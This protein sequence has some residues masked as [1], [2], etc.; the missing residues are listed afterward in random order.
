MGQVN[1]DN[2]SW[3]FE[4]EIILVPAPASSLSEIDS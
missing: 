2:S 4:V 3:G 1:N